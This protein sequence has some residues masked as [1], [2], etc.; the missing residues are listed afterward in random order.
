[1]KRQTLLVFPAVL[2]LGVLAPIVG[3]AAHLSAAAMYALDGLVAVVV[4]SVSLEVTLGRRAATAETERPRGLWFQNL[5]G[6]WNNETG[7][8]R[9]ARVA[10]ESGG[11]LLGAATFFVAD[12]RGLALVGAVVSTFLIGVLG[13]EARGHAE[14]EGN[15]EA[16]E[17][18]TQRPRSAPP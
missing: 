15:V 2:A 9:R 1:V 7:L 12:H 13:A 11:T 17:S 4:V 16:N 6:W 3:W 8:P 10:I 18:K 5:L 14:P